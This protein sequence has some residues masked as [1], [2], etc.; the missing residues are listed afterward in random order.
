M[1]D[2][3]AERSG[4]LEQQHR[5]GGVRIRGGVMVVQQAG[6]SEASQA[7]AHDHYAVVVV[8][9]RHGQQRHHAPRHS[10]SGGRRT[11][12]APAPALPCPA[13]QGTLIGSRPAIERCSHWGAECRVQ[14]AG[15]GVRV[16]NILWN[17]SINFHRNCRCEIRVILVTNDVVPC[18]Q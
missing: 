2:P 4:R 9:A 18:Q 14:S 16:S 1:L 12:P 11:T 3:A 5:G 17:V 6:R 7:A 15:C 10:T 13:L 8:L